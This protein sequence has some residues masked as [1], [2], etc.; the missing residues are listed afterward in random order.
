MDGTNKALGNAIGCYSFSGPCIQCLLNKN[1][2]I[3]KGFKLAF[4]FSSLVAFHQLM[5]ASRS[6]EPPFFWLFGFR[7]YE[8]KYNEREN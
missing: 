2:V 5:S 7:S 8:T 6:D 4:Y 1:K 3:H